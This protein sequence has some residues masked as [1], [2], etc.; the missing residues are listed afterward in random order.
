M[1]G[2]SLVDFIRWNYNIF[3]SKI[4]VKLDKNYSISYNLGILDDVF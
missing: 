2:L 3:Y 1:F 4:L